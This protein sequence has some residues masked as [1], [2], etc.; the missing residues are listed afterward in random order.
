[1]KKISLF[2]IL[3]A[4]VLSAPGAVKADS[5][6]F[7]QTFGDLEIT[8]SY[9]FGFNLSSVQDVALSLDGATV[10]LTHNGNSNNAGE[11]WLITSAGALS[12]GTLSSSTGGDNFVTDSWTLS[13]AILSEIT[14]QNPWALTVHLFDNTTGTDKIIIKESVLNVNFTAIPDDPPTGTPVPEP[15]TALL[16]ASGVIGMGMLRR[17]KK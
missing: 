11:F 7:T 10:S 9:S 5:M 2:A 6:S 1:M 13:S 3:L 14:S 16:L 12:I 17:R 15:S 8:N 4:V